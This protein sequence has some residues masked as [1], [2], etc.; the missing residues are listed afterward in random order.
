LSRPTP[1]KP[2]TYFPLAQCAS[3]LGTHSLFLLFATIFLPRS[4]I[5]LGLELPEQRTS[6][7]RPQP[8]FLKP[9][10]SRPALTVTWIS[11]GVFVV[12]VS[13]S[14]WVRAWWLGERRKVVQEA[15]RKVKEKFISMRNAW[16]TTVV[17]V[18]IIVFVLILFGAPMAS[19][20]LETLALSF[21]LSFL[22]T[23]TPAYVL[24]L[25]RF[26]SFGF[27]SAVPPNES[28][29]TATLIDKLEWTRL[30]SELK[31]NTP[32][33]RMIVYPIIGTLLGTWVG[34]IPLALDWDRPWQAWPL[35]P[36]YGAVFGHIV[37]AWFVVV[38]LTV[39]TLVR[40][41]KTQRE[42]Q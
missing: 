37:G 29:E 22:I 6:L 16:V 9:L 33:E 8:E 19:Y 28:Y 1:A 4:S 2:D 24:P 10:T 17:F 38:Y 13:W 3:V 26:T 32:T 7:D 41:G 25:P 35:L 23:L 14:G 31:M 12:N 11:L 34:V 18:P 30:F 5:Y 40:I 27:S 36:A 21:L 42:M 15:G 20:I 39:D